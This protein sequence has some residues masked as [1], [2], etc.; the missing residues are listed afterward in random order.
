MQL[1]EIIKEIL[2]KND[3]NVNHVITSEDLIPY[4]YHLIKCDYFRGVNKLD[5]IG[6]N[7]TTCLDFKTYK[8]GVDDVFDGGEL[9]IKSIQLTPPIY[10]LEMLHKRPENSA[11]ISPIIYDVANYV[12][13]RYIT[14]WFD[15]SGT[16][17]VTEKHNLISKF[18]DVVDNPEKYMAPQSYGLYIT[19]VKLGSSS[20]FIGGDKPLLINI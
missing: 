15:P 13:S 11:L 5:F 16:N 9:I 19:W 17:N 8:V 2:V 1:E 14:V 20:D 10:D 18:E 4:Y 12:P 7:E 6:V 3:Y